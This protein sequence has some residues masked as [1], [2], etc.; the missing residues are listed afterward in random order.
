MKSPNNDTIYIDGPRKSI[1]SNGTVLIDEE[2]VK[3]MLKVYKNI[4]DITSQR[5][6]PC[7][8]IYD[9]WEPCG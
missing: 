8:G 7:D 5:V 3:S 4:P 6:A 1:L 9:V 2:D